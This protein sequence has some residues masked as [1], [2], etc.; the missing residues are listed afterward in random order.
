MDKTYKVY[1][2][3]GVPQLKCTGWTVCTMSL[4]DCFKNVFTTRYARNMKDFYNCN[5]RYDIVQKT[6]KDIYSDIG[7]GAIFIPFST[8]IDRDDV[9]KYLKAGL[10]VYF[11]RAA[12]YNTM[13]KDYLNYM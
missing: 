7:E 12:E 13:K 10:T 9:I 6:I 1:I 3:K 8:T 4:I 11:M 5:F 2:F